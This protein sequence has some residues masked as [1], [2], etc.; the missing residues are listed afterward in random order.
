MMAALEL[1]FLL[2]VLASLALAYSFR[3]YIQVKTNDKMAA[4]LKDATAEV[5]RLRA[6]MALHVGNLAS[7]QGPKHD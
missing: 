5:V 2:G 7:T 1:G 6:W 4:D 3:E